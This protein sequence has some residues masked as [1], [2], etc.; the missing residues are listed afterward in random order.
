MSSATG[1][2]RKSKRKPRRLTGG[3]MGHQGKWLDRGLRSGVS[4]RCELHDGDIIRRCVIA[5][6]T[7]VSFGRGCPR[8]S[9]KHRNARTGEPYGHQIRATLPP[10]APASVDGSG[11]LRHDCGQMV[12]GRRRRGLH[13]QLG[14]LSTGCESSSSS[15]CSVQGLGH[16][17]KGVLHP[18]QRQPLEI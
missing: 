13:V 14:T 1:R 7:H 6:K 4:W 11:F 16:W 17:E 5:V 3:A 15:G 12:T 2:K 8:S 10:C 18:K 9:R